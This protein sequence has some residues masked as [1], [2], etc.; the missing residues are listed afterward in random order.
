LE[1]EQWRAIGAPDDV[2]DGDAPSFGTF[3]AD[4]A[5]DNG[6]TTVY[7][8]NEEEIPT[9]PEAKGNGRRLFSRGLLQSEGT[10]ESTPTPTITKTAE[11][12]YGFA[13]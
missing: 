6:T 3:T 4:S 13:A 11:V 12:L 7:N 9:L 10:E 8:I 1:C 2:G 5:E